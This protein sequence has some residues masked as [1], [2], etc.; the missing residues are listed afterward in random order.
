VDA[1]LGVRLTGPVGGGEA[2]VVVLPGETVPLEIRASDWR[3]RPLPGYV[4]HGFVEAKAGPCPGVTPP[5]VSTDHLGR[6]RFELEASSP[7]RAVFHAATPDGVHNAS[8]PLVVRPVVLE[9]TPDGS[10]AEPLTAG[11]AR[12]LRQLFGPGCQGL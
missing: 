7:A 4:L 10:G 8:V 3:G 5:Q 2:V 9:W 12:L 1:R 11:Q 6:A